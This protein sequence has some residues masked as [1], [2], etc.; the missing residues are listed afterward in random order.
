M[1]RTSLGFLYAGKG[2]LKLDQF[3]QGDFLICKEGTAGLLILMV[4][5]TNFEEFLINKNHYMLSFLGLS[6]SSKHLCIVDEDL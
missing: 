2:L 1:V 4:L 6:L 5:M 3:W